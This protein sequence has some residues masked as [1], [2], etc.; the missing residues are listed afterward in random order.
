MPLNIFKNFIFKL[1]VYVHMSAVLMEARRGHQIPLE[2]ELQ[3]MVS[4]LVWVL[5]TELRLCSLE[6]QSVHLTTE[7]SLQSHGCLLKFP[8]RPQ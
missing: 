7:P 4:L 2:L 6:E 3:A 5:G 1:Y 8:R